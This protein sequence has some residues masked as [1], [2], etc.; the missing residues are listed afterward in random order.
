MLAPANK[1]PEQAMEED[2]KE[3]KLRTPNDQPVVR[4]T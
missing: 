3:A 1:T 2:E 4:T